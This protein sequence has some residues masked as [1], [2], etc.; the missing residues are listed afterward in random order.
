LFNEVISLNIQWRDV[1]DPSAELHLHETMTFPNIVK[2]IGHVVA[3][4]PVEV[5]LC[6][7]MHDDSCYVRGTLSADVTYRCSRCLQEF[8]E[9]LDVPFRERFV[10]AAQEV[11]DDEDE[12]IAVVGEEIDLEPW[13]EQAIILA[14]PYRPLCEQECAGLC[15]V[16]GMNRNESSCNC[17]DERIDPRLADLAKFFEQN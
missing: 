2:E 1:R 4:S 10:K 12:R 17:N 7:S 3:M 8:V 6:A 14:L 9:R 11:V 5:D 16:C 13:M 15:P